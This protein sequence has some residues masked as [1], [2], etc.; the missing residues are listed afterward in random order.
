MTERVI[1]AKKALAAAGRVSGRFDPHRLSLL[2]DY[3]RASENSV[4]P[5]PSNTMRAGLSDQTVSR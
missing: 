4:K 1:S 2:A 5:A 3:A